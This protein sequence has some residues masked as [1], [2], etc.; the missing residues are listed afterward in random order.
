MKWGSLNLYEY[1]WPWGHCDNPY[2]KAGCMLLLKASATDSILQVLFLPT[3]LTGPFGLT[4]KLG[5]KVYLCSLPEIL[6]LDRN[7]MICGPVQNAM[8]LPRSRNLI[9]LQVIKVLP[10]ESL[11]LQAVDHE[12]N[13]NPPW[14]SILL[15]SELLSTNRRYQNVYF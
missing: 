12:G 8:S 5:G 1:P 13:V 4:L 11:V 9:L 15:I 2:F 6:Q 7:L 3:W 14:P 10:F